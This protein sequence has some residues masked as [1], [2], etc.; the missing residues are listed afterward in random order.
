[1]AALALGCSGSTTSGDGPADPVGTSAGSGGSPEA[2]GGEA[3]GGAAGSSTG[4][5]ASGGSSTGGQ[6]TGGSSAGDPNSL[7]LWTLN[8]LNPSNPLSSSADVNVRTQLVIDAINAEQPDL[9][10]FQ[11]VVSSASVPNRAEFIAN[12]TGYEWAWQME[13]SAVIYD[14]GIAVL[15]KWP[16]VDTASVELPHKDLVLV[17]RF[18]LGARVTTP[19]GPV[20][21]YSTHM[22][23]G[24]SEEQSADQAAKAYEFITQRSGTTPAFFAG[25][26]NAE[27]ETPSMRF[28]RGE[29]DHGGVTGNFVDLWLATNPDDVGYTIDAEDPNK[30]I[31]YIYASGSTSA[32]VTP[33]QCHLI[34]DAPVSGVY[35]S[36][37]IGVSCTVTV[38]P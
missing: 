18:A 30:R 26:L 7:T 11:E 5:E 34:F 6:G 14:E 22:T 25:D 27:P 32:V 31:D 19:A 33:D 1:M 23:V 35:A 10:A 37:H 17:T 16:I 15:S 3:S 20:G 29:T 2:S 4:G 36:D 9:I 28:L 38:T 13:Y 8:L 21:F 24:G 12:A